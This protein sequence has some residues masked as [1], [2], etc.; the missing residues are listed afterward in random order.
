MNIEFY[1]KRIKEQ[2]DYI[3][4]VKKRNSSEERKKEIMDCAKIMLMKMND[5][6]Q[7]EIF[8]VITKID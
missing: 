8:K 7:L 1:L 4:E 5:C 3:E 6:L 2:V